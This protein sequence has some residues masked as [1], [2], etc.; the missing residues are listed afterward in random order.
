MRKN[1]ECCGNCQF[2]EGGIGVPGAR[3][4]LDNDCLT[5]ILKKANK[6]KEFGRVFTPEDVEK[7]KDLICMPAHW[8]CNAWAPVNNMLLISK[9]LENI[10]CDLKEILQVLQDFNS[11]NK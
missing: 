11:K 1:V 8:Y 6:E 10:H 9:N 7:Y 3:R 5:C 4:Q 2:A